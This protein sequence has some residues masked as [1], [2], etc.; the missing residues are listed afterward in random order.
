MPKPCCE[1][2]YDD[3]EESIQSLCYIL[4]Q[5]TILKDRFLIYKIYSNTLNT[6]QNTEKKNRNYKQV[7]NRR[8][9]GEKTESCT[10]IQC[11][12]KGNIIYTFDI[13]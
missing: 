1:D 10:T 7:S 12:A 3:D 9:T 8:P 6:L 2:D 13:S 4:L 5:I 11:L